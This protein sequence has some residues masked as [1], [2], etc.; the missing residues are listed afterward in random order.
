MEHAPTVFG[1]YAARGAG[2]VA[3]AT[4]RVSPPRGTDGISL[5]ELEEQHEKRHIEDFTK[6][7]IAKKGD[8]QQTEF[9]D[10]DVDKSNKIKLRRLE[11]QKEVEQAFGVDAAGMKEAKGVGRIIA[12]VNFAFLTVVVG[13]EID[14]YGF[15]M[16]F[17]EY[18]AQD[19]V[20]VRALLLIGP[21]GYLLA[22]FMYMYSQ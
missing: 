16:S 11:Q 18:W 14:L 3:G 12:V 2:S 10:L 15:A 9:T 17:K 13:C 19:N 5:Q 4:S 21:I 8:V 6:A 22:T 1:A 20:L 7:R